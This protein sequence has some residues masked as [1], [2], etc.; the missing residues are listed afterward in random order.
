LFCGLIVLFLFQHLGLSNVTHSN[1]N[2]FD[3]ANPS[4]LGV[5]NI[6]EF[7][8]GLQFLRDAF[9]FVTSGNSVEWYW[10]GAYD[11]EE[12]PSF[13]R[14]VGKNWGSVV[15]GSFVNAFLR[16]PSNIVEQL[17][18]HQSSYCGKCGQSCSN[19]C[20]WCI[21]FFELIRTDSYS[22]INVFGTTYCDAGRECE[23][24]C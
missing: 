23:K 11:D 22:Y 24:L 9:I 17:I 1:N 18:C 4:F 12:S 14:L 15:A 20:N 19:N 7:L 16:I 10:S 5:L 3:F 6:I 13:N 2:F 8:W 21:S